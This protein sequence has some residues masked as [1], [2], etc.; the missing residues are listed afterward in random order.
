[1]AIVEVKN[2][3][4]AYSAHDAVSELSFEVEKGEMFAVF[5]ANGSGKTTTARHL[6]AL[7]KP[8]KG[9]VSVCGLDTSDE[10]NTVAI[11]KKCGMIFSH[12]RERFLTS[13]AIDEVAFSLLCAGENKNDVK[14]K[15]VEYLKLTGMT[16]RENERLDALD[17]YDSLSVQIASVLASAPEIIVF[18]DASTELIGENREKVFA[19]LKKINEAGKTLILF[20]NQYDEAALSERVLLLAKG[21]TAA[22][23]N[24][25]DILTDREL[26][27][28]AGIELPFPLK[29]YYDLLDGDI[30]LRRPPLNMKELVDEIC[31]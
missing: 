7:L 17:A 3:S 2:I 4:F 5:G 21:C 6:N 14:E 30:R 25:R 9:T 8:Q 26:L 11:R 19:L 12:S 27:Q 15:A 13:Y 10:K 29:V 18:D 31:L 24:S 23:G 1:M 22:Y 16:G 28:K 20:T